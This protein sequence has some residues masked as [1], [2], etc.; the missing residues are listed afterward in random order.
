MVLPTAALLGG[1]KKTRKRRSGAKLFEEIAA[2]ESSEK[3]IDFVN[4]VFHRYAGIDNDKDER[5][6][7]ESD[8]GEFGTGDSDMDKSDGEEKDIKR[9]EGDEVH[10]LKVQIDEVDI[11]MYYALQ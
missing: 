7:N 2:E 5:E 11:G 9:N 6:L 8:V 1:L 3:E 4:D 10:S